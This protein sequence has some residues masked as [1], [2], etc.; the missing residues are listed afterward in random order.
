L[1]RSLTNSD[2]NAFQILH[3]I[4]IGEPEH[5]IS[6]RCKPLI[7]PAVVAETGF[8]IVAL[9]VDFDELTGMRDEVRDVTTHWALPAKSESGKSMRFQMTPKQRFG[10]R[11]RAP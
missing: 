1:L 2:Y 4:I 9:A 6:A 5:A 8:E 10:T 3:H 7:T 11:H